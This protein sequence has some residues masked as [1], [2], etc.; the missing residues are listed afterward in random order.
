MRWLWI[1][2]FVLPLSC[3]PVEV[4]NDAGDPFDAEPTPDAVEGDGFVHHQYVLSRLNV[5]EDASQAQALALNIDGDAEGRAD[6]AL[7]Q[8]LAALASQSPLDLQG[9]ISLSVR[10][11]AIINLLDVRAPEDLA[12]APG[13][14]AWVFPGQ[15]PDPAPC[16]VPS[17][18]T[19]CAQHLEG[20]G[21]FDTVGTPAEDSVMPGELGAGQFVGG[22]GGAELQI[23]FVAGDGSSR[24][25]SL[26]GARVE[27]TLDGQEPPVSGI[28]AGGVREED[29][30]SSVIPEVHDT[31]TAIIE[32]ECGPNCCP[33]GSDGEALVDT[34]DTNNDCAVSLEELRG[35]DLIMSLFAPDVDLLDGNGDFN[36]LSDGEKDSLSIGIGV[37]A[38]GASF[39]LPASF[40]E[41]VTGGE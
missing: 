3:D 30:Q 36:P 29:V 17:D 7:G 38:V 1:W 40:G 31:V 39:D 10:K 18:P 16:V 15:N 34:F 23:T 11:G 27:L 20:T 19:T 4:S 24:T 6:N 14:G 13:V 28:L 22:P 33:A 26:V 12:D 21:S 9:E 25:L 2:L 41:S 32:A 5:P 35:N 8:A 37:E